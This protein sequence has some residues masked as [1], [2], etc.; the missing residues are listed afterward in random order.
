MATRLSFLALACFSL[1][2]SAYSQSFT[3]SP[4]DDVWVY[5]HAADPGYDPIGRVWGDSVDSYVPSWPPIE[6]F[7]YTYLRF[8]LSGIAPGQYQL[9]SAN[10][11]VTHRV[12][13][14]GTFT[15]E[16]GEAYPLEARGL[17]GTFS[18]AT[19]TFTNPTNPYPEA[20][21]FGLGNMNNYNPSS[22]FDITMNLRNT[23]FQNEFNTAVNSG[24]KT[25]VIALT[26]KMPVTGQVGA[27]PYRVFTRD[28]AVSGQR[29]VLHVSL[30]RLPS[31]GIV[32]IKVQPIR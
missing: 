10:L 22:S 8:D 21:L 32:P 18:E 19:W 4:S 14:S 31:L 17:S 11:R 6:D 25:L 15:R 20:K 29:P 16:A 2:V 30:K 7:S 23:V 13:S 12:T 5:P 9:I 28:Y 3:L 1:S 26:S 24:A 27:L